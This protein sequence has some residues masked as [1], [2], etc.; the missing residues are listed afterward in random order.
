MWACYFRRRPTDA[1]TVLLFRDDATY[2]RWADRLFGDKDLPHFGYYKPDRRTLVMNIATGTGTLVHELTHALIAYDFPSVPRW[3]NEGLASLHEQCHVHAD[4]IVGAVNW[5]L[6]ALQQAV[7]SR[8]LRPLAELVSRDGFYGPQQGMN[9]AQA[10]YFVLYMQERGLLKRFY[11]CFRRRAGENDAA[12]KTIQE[13]FGAPVET[14][15]TE[16]LRWVLTL[17]WPQE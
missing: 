14:V 7:R 17:Q 8:K 9:Y 15:E 1:I 5:R 2:R 4:R 16:F 3:F 13:V 6:P 11:E 12:V 10:R